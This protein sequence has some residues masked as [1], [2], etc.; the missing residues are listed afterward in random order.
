VKWL[1]RNK[2]LVRDKSTGR[3]RPSWARFYEISGTRALFAGTD[4]KVKY[5]LAEVSR[6]KRTGYSYGG[7]Y[8]SL[9]LAR[10]YP[11]W[12]KKWAPGKN[13]LARPKNREARQP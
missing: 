5:S 10:D 12:Q 3:E 2:K 8:A 11:A 13:V 1:D 6:E 7:D 9:L 4:S